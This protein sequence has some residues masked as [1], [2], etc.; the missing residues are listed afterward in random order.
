MPVIDTGTGEVRLAQIYVA[1]LGYSKAIHAQ[2]TWTQGEADWIAG[3]D[4][5]L[6]AFGG[7]PEAIVPDNLKAAVTHR[8]HP[9]GAVTFRLRSRSGEIRWAG[10]RRL[11]LGLRYSASM[12]MRRI[13]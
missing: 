10:W 3:N 9:V 8:P 7:V 13:R 12:L 4:A 11:V 2:A 6:I 1:T 5:A